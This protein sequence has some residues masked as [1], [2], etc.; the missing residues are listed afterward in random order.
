MFQIHRMR[1]GSLV[2][3]GLFL[4]LCG[5]ARAEQGLQSSAPA[6][7]E[8]RVLE[9]QVPPAA[10]Q[11]ERYAVTYRMEIISVLRSTS[12]VKP[13]E[14]I[15]V[16]SYALAQG[17]ADTGERAPVLLTPGW[18]GVAYLAPDPKAA[19]PEARWQFVVAAEGDSFA[20]LA[21]APPSLRWTQ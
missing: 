14:T 4:A 21:P 5:G 20:D 15:V 16:R 9:A 13:G 11:G 17:A 12:R 10:E 1:I 6:A 3:L 2:T 8:V 7:L 18:I 19:G